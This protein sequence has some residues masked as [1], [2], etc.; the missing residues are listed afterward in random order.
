MP[1]FGLGA[2]R[3]IALAG[4]KAEQRAAFEQVFADGVDI[5]LDYLLRCAGAADS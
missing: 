1:P 4:G 5:V 2:D 3:V